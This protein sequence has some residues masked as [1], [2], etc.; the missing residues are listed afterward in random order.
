MCGVESWPVEAGGPGS[1]CGCADG[2]AG[3]GPAS[4]A[5]KGQ[6]ECWREHA[7]KALK[8]TAGV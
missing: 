6:E 1:G 7:G 4:S 3:Q 2:G 8:K 5:A